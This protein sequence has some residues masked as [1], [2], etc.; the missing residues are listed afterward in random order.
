MTIIPS[1]SYR[2]LL[3]GFCVFFQHT[4]CILHPHCLFSCCGT[5]GDLMCMLISIVDINL[6]YQHYLEVYFYLQNQAETFI[7]MTI[8]I[9]L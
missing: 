6:Y 9:S 7:S 1:M 4:V 3:A 5:M 2:L 8:F